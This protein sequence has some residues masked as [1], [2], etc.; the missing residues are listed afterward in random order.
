MRAGIHRAEPRDE[1][2]HERERGDVDEEYRADR[3]PERKELPLRR[4]ARPRPAREHAVARVVALGVGTTTSGRAGDPRAHRRRDR[5]A[6]RAELREA[7]LA[8]DED[9]VERDFQREAERGSA[10]SPRAA[11][12]SRSRTPGT[13][14]RAASPEPPTPSRPGTRASS[15]RPRARAGSAR[16]AARDAS[17]ARSRSPRGRARAMRSGAPPRRSRRSARRPCSC[18]TVGR[19]REEHA[20]QRHEQRHVD[21]GADADRGEID[22]CRS[23]RPSPCR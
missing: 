15:P 20:H 12:R 14:G 18:A 11:A 5:A 21:A 19:Q 8:V 17:P 7:E 23:A 1:E 6:G 9:P 4:G 22:A 16:G 3:D 10:P 13:R 2:R